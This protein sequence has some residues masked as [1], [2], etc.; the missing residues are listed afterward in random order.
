MQF[1]KDMITLNPKDLGSADIPIGLI[2]LCFCV[3]MI[4]ATV[5][6][7]LTNATVYRVIK[8]LSRHK[9]T[10]AASAK[11]L[12]AL[13]LAEDR[14]VLRALKREKPI[15]G[16]YISSVSGEGAPN[17]PI[18]VTQESAQE[19]EDLPTEGDHTPEGEN[20]PAAEKSPAERKYFLTPE[21]SD[22]AKELLS[23]GEVGVLQTVGYCAL[24]L[25]LYFGIAAALTWLLPAL[26]S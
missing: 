21:M 16:R 8:A 15:L 23:R 24:L 7:S 26:L 10:D 6:I 20:A 2:L 18:A 19:S 25:L 5:V 4:A 14:W 12:K 13:G 17:A 3:G 11:G 9:C 1:F 22:R